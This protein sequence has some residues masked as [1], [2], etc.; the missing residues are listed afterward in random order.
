MV[1]DEYIRFILDNN[2]HRFMH[3]YVKPRPQDELGLPISR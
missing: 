2:N 3:G 1:D